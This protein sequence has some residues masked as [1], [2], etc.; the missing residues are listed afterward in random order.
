MSYAVGES[1]SRA[2]ADRLNQANRRVGG[3]LLMRAIL[4]VSLATE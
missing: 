1:I 3:T 2:F 4:G